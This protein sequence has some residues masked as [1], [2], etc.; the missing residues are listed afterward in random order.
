MPTV[1]RVFCFA[2]NRLK[3]LAMFS[4]SLRTISKSITSH[5]D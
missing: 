1:H 3:V 5:F 4:V 2:E